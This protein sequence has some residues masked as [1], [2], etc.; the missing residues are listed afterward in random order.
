VVK[1]NAHRYIKKT[2]AASNETRY[3]IT[4]LPANAEKLN[5][6]IHAHWAID[7]NLHWALDDDFREKIIKS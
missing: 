4:S 3:Y 6:A 7:N 5:K 1:V 2:G